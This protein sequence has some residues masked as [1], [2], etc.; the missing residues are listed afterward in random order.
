[1]VDP[2]RLYIYKK[3]KL[4]NLG[5]VVYWMSRDQRV[6]ENWALLFA[7]QK[8]NECKSP[9]LVVFTL[10]DG[11]L[12]ANLR[13]YSFMIDGLREVEVE[14]QKLGASF[15]LIT[16]DP[17]VSLHSFINQTK[18]S[19]LISDFDPLRIKVEWKKWVSDSLQIDHIEVDSHN[20][21]PCRYVSQK[22]EFGAYTIRPKINRLLNRFLIDFPIIPGVIVKSK[23]P[24]TNWD[25]ILKKLKIDRNI[26]PVDWLSPGPSKANKRLVDFISEGLIGYSSKRNDPLVDGQSNLSPYLHFGQISSQR[27]A[28]EVSKSFASSEDKSAFLEE[29]IVRKELSDN[30]CLYNSKY[31]SVEGFH[32]W[33]KTTINDHRQDEREYLYTLNDLELSKTHDPLWNAAQLEMV[34][35]GKMHGYMRMYW[36]KKILEWTAS[37]EQA[38]DFAIFLNDKYSLDGRDPNGYAGIAWSIGGVHDRAWTERPIFGKIRYMNYNGCKRK[39]N[40]D[41]YIEKINR[42]RK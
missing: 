18:A 12:G 35:T 26:L 31:D 23:S 15:Y 20:I 42:L 38:M 32:T 13:H 11:F 14:L 28:I 9:L 3:A 6:F 41:G 27:V 37:P 7:I 16:G 33:A 39:F 22:M 10:S 17:K 24:I 5:P 2:D 29:L 21:V 36:A 8:A 4:K 1:M 30:F 25:D 19:L 34:L 40:V